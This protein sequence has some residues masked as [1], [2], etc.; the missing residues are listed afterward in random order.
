MSI[1]E[2]QFTELYTELYER[3]NNNNTC[4]I[5][6]DSND[7]IKISC[8]HYYHENC[9][10][11]YYLNSKKSFNC[12]YCNKLNK[13]IKCRKCKKMNISNKCSTCNTNTNKENISDIINENS[14]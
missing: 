2:K 12:P 11:L 5:C 14:N 10:N 6:Y 7:I 8:G 13:L 1:T 3:D 9:I 4:M